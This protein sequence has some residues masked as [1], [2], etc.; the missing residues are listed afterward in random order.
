VLDFKGWVRVVKVVRVVFLKRRKK[1]GRVWEM[2]GGDPHNP[3]SLHPS[4]LEL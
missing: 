3:H 1:V 4:N 2:L